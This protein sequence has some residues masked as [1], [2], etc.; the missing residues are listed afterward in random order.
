[1]KVRPYV[2]KTKITELFYR[3]E[4]LS[5]LFIILLLFL[6]L[7]LDHYLIISRWK[8]VRQVDFLFQNLILIYVFSFLNKSST[9]YNIIIN[10][11]GSLT[12]SFQL[13]S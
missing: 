2:N 11:C 12:L 7:L 8:N 3:W 13:V 6:Y 9:E 5:L 4:Q 10:F 1:M